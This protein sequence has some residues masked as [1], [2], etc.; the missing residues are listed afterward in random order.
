[1]KKILIHS[2]T[3]NNNQMFDPNERDGCNEPMIYLRDRLYKLGYS[4]KTADNEALD[5]CEWVIFFE[6]ISVKTYSG[7]RGIAR[8]LKSILQRKPLYRN[9]YAECV[10]AG[11][12]DKIALFLWEPPS[13]SPK[14]WNSEMHKLFPILFTWHDNYI[15]GKKLKKI[16]FTQISQ[17]PHVS[18]IPF[19]EKK[20]LVNIS[21]NKFSSHPR[22]L[23][24]ARRASIRYFEKH[25]PENFDLYG[26]GWNSSVNLFEK[27]LP[28]NPQI[29]PSYRGTVKNKWE[30]LPNYRFSLCYENIYNEP[31]FVTEKI[32]DCMRAGC[33]PIY[34]GAPN[35]EDYVDE[36]AFIDR[37]KFKTDI[38]LESYLVNMDEEEYNVHL[39]A[40]Q[41]YLTGNKFRKFL[42]ENFAD[43]II[44]SLEL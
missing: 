6:E 36:G 44:R 26:V 25:Q 12:E 22:E 28:I 35:I 10:K 27:I 41:V 38:E 34:W 13:V 16:Y 9:L 24:S 1:M 4:L 33:V 37:R 19:E 21:M 15:D 40:I 7:L 5:D 20:L 17:F 32:F 3:G 2:L 29:Y 23:Y 11:M 31:G 39:D 30:V 14:N 43:T 42:P 8:K 18:K